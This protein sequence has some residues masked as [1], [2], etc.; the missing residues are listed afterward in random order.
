MCHTNLVSNQEF[1]VYQSNEIHQRTLPR[2]PT[3]ETIQKT[4][5]LNLVLPGIEPSSFNAHSANRFAIKVA[6]NSNNI[7]RIINKP[8]KIFKHMM[9]VPWKCVIC[10]ILKTSAV[11]KQYYANYC[12]VSSATRRH[13]SN[14]AHNA[15]TTQKSV[16]DVFRIKYSLLL[17][18][19]LSA[20]FRAGCRSTHKYA[21]SISSASI[22]FS[23]RLTSF[24]VMFSWN[25]KMISQ[26]QEH[27]E[28][29]L[30]ILEACTY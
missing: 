26:R 5:F 7:V 24:V 15:L 2:T 20:L 10:I 17:F 18:L 28:I 16:Q 12:R 30:L 4:L 3:L 13:V 22:A 29:V 25:V 6:E 8:C 1:S 27:S 11:V 9:Y 19:F 21:N 23:C 14:H